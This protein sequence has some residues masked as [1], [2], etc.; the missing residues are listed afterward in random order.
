LK[1]VLPI[2]WPKVTLDTHSHT[3]V[4]AGFEYRPE[5]MRNSGTNVPTTSFLDPKYEAISAV[6]Y[7]RAGVSQLPRRMGEDFIFIHNP[8]A[9]NPVP[10]GFLKLGKEYY[11]QKNSELYAVSGHLKPAR[12]GRVKTSHLR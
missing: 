5:I 10:L 6:L 8:L 4:D 1:A 11:E 9:K 2:G 7:S 12:D 3:A